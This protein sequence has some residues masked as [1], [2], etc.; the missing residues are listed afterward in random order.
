M[1]ILF[2]ILLWSILPIIT[3]SWNLHNTPNRIEWENS[4]DQQQRF[5]VESPRK[6]ILRFDSNDSYKPIILIHHS[7][8]LFVDNE[9]EFNHI[10]AMTGDNHGNL[11]ISDCRDND[12]GKSLI[13]LKLSWIFDI[14]YL[15]E[16]IQT[17]SNNSFCPQMIELSNKDGIPALVLSSRNTDN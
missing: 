4:N 3:G 1:K 6:Q 17:L 12:D 7:K 13:V 2:F 14:T 15:K 8:G 16:E 10:S 5:I 9:E 11:Y